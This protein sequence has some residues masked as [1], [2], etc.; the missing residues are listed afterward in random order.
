MQRPTEENYQALREWFQAAI[1]ARGLDY[2][3]EP[4]SYDASSEYDFAYYRLQVEAREYW[5]SRYGYAPSDEWLSRAFFD[6]EIT[7]YS[8]FQAL[9]N[10]LGW[11]R[12][13]LARRRKPG[14]LQA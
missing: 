9:R 2:R 5:L 13:R 11:L 6:A 10:P 1:K 3:S 4:F 12:R 14:E 7:R 8:R